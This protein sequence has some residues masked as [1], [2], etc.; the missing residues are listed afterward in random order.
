MWR[1]IIGYEGRYE[2]SF[3][4]RVRNA[5]TK[6]I[7]SQRINKHGYYCVNLGSG[8]IHTVHRLVSKAFIENES[9]LPCV[10]HK[11]ENKL[12]NIA[13]NLE[14]CTVGYNNCY[15]TVLAR[16]AASRGKPVSA[17]SSD[18][19]VGEFNSLK[20]A[21]EAIGVDATCIRRAARGM[22]ARAG[23]LRWKYANNAFIH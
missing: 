19:L 17:Y 10:N 12:N 11:D 13:S 14:W 23:G 18:C 6:Q 5:K 8:N 4:G 22:Q 1:D 3:D 7:K 2:V 16:A 21:S 15:G 20:E 9:N